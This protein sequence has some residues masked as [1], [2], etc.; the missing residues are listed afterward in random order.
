MSLPGLLAFYAWTLCSEGQG[1]SLAEPSSEAMNQYD[2]DTQILDETTIQ[3]LHMLP[4][5]ELHV[6]LEGAIP[7]PSMLELIQKYGGT[8][9]DRRLIERLCQYRDFSDFIATWVLIGTYI[10]DYEDYQ[11]VAGAVA[12]DLARQHIIYAEVLYSPSRDSAKHLDPQLITEA[13]RRGFSEHS[14]DIELNLIADL[15]WDNGPEEAKQLVDRLS[16]VQSA[17]VV[18]IGIGG[19][20]QSSPT[21]AFAEVFRTAREYGFHTN[22]HAGESAGAK[23]IW[24]AIQVLNVERIG[25]GTS[26]REDP[27]LVAY[28]RQAQIPIEMC[29]VSNVRTR[30]VSNMEDHPIKDFF[31]KG[32]AVCVNTDD[33]LLFNTSLLKE[34]SLLI[35]HL[36]LTIDEVVQLA[37]NAI[38]YAWCDAA[39]KDKLRGQVRQIHDS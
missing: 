37:G 22:A 15:I 2:I 9:D 38:D 11:F 33:P 36:G 28:L 20:E 26:A 19:T 12:A 29:P 8:P 39:T 13:I 10:R 17:G 30:A 1:L 35:S 6:H 32:L 14:S 21:Q 7:Y 24:E 25:H 23:R 16:E 31:R 34:Y 18:G 5:V 3:F 4:K 27:E